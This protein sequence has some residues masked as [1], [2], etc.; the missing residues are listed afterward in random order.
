MKKKAIASVYV[1]SDSLDQGNC[2]SWTLTGYMEPTSCTDSY[3]DKFSARNTDAYM[4]THCTCT[5]CTVIATTKSW[6]R[7][8]CK[9]LPSTCSKPNNSLAPTVIEFKCFYKIFAGIAQTFSYNAESDR[10]SII[11]IS[12]INLWSGL[13]YI[14]SNR[15]SLAYWFSKRVSTPPPPSSLCVTTNKTCFVI[16]FLHVAWS[17]YYWWQSHCHGP[18]SPSSQTFWGVL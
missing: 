11:W 12:I 16:F 1:F 2:C 7:Y 4:Y 17:F 5:L 3:W 6:V 13:F 18:V 9:L 15:R 8:G 10:I 14:I